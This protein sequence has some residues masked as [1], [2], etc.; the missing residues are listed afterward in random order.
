MHSTRVSSQPRTRGVD[1]SARLH[2]TPGA[3]AARCSGGESRGTRRTFQ[4]AKAAGKPGIGRG[5]ARQ[6]WASFRR[7]V[8]G[9]EQKAVVVEWDRPTR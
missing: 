1:L 3:A 5:V 9:P 2:A 8:V 4:V 7:L 6:K